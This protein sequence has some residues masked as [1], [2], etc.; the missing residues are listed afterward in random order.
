MSLIRWDAA[1]Y[2]DDD[3]AI[4]AYLNEAAAQDD[5]K[6]LQ[7]AL[8]DIARAKGM[9]GI[10]EQVGVGRESLY[11]SLSGA[12]NPS[13]QTV[14]RVVRALGGRITITTAA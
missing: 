11:K 7:A 4:I 12:G 13:F 9:R 10:A 2:L 3:D 8:G 14:A 5:P 6:L 1:D